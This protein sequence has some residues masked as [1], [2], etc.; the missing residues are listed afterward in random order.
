MK[1]LIMLLAVLSLFG[2]CSKSEMKLKTE[3][4]S[5]TNRVIDGVKVSLDKSIPEGLGAHENFALTIKKDSL[6]QLFLMSSALIENIP[7]PTGNHLN[8]K[9]VYFKKNGNT[10]GLFEL[11]DGRYETSAIQT[12]LLLT[13]F[14][15]LSETE[16]TIVIDFNKGMSKLFYT[17]ST[18]TSDFA[19]GSDGE[20]SV[21]S[22]TD[23]FVDRAEIVGNVLYID[24]L[25]RV[26][27][28]EEG[29]EDNLAMRL[30][31]N[32]QSYAY[33]D[34]FPSKLSSE[35]NK[36]GYFEVNPL[37][38]PG[39]TERQI[40]IAKWNVEKPITFY[41]SRNTPTDLIQPLTDAILYWNQAFKE[42][43]GKEPLRVEML[44]E[45]V[46]LYTPGYNIIQWMDNDAAGA[47]YAD[48]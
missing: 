35:M 8:E 43:I 21:F 28:A 45:G 22:I 7:N 46:D 17:S 40:M 10:I 19:N 37:I 47:A 24:Q 36:V 3:P 29:K 15:T 20:Q 42:A 5:E 25:V 9:V 4:L 33:D 23:S 48:I 6:K 12:E 39:S 27:I 30:K 11:T 14:P 18:Y 1:K 38:V 26:N 44:P 13:T 34:K 2:A 31:Y 16:D 32:F 41:L